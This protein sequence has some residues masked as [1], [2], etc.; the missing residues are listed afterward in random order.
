MRYGKLLP[1]NRPRQ[2]REKWAIIRASCAWPDPIAAAEDAA[3]GAKTWS[4]EFG[5]SVC[6]FRTTFG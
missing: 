2:N 6:L 5:L 3:Y 4:R 1:V